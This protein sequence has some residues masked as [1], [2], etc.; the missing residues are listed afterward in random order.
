MSEKEEFFG[1]IPRDARVSRIHLVG[2]EDFNEDGFNIG[3]GLGRTGNISRGGIELE[4]KSPLP[5]KTRARLSIALAGNTKIEVE[6]E[7]RHLEMLDNGLAKM[8]M[9]FVDVDET[10]QKQIDDYINESA[11]HEVE[12]MDPEEAIDPD[13][14]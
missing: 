7:V 4:L 8:G 9:M 5:L 11:S 13:S 3:F 14:E 2:V 6:A 10:T 1:G 12:V